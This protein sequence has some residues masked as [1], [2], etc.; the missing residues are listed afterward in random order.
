MHTERA[1]RFVRKSVL[2]AGTAPLRSPSELARAARSV[3]RLSQFYYVFIAYLIGVSTLQFRWASDGLPPTA[4]LWP[5]KLAQQLFS[6]VWLGW[7]PAITVIGLLCAIGAAVR[8]A[9]WPLR[10]GTFLYLFV[11]IALGNSYGSINHGQ[12]T[13]LFVSATLLFLPRV[14][15]GASFTFRDVSACL[16]ALSLTHVA[17]LLPYTLSGFWKLWHGGTEAF[18]PGALQR[19]LLDRLLASTGDV[20]FLLPVIAEHS[21]LSWV[22]WLATL[23]LEFFALLVVFR[24]HLHRPYAVALILFHVATHWTMGIAFENNVLLMGIFLVL[25]PLAPAKFSLAGALSSLPIVGIPVRI[26]TRRRSQA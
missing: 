7:H 14:R 21:G 22:M 2:N 1:L 4:P 19:I 25:S 26:W 10:F 18:A 20:P 6:G 11:H 9:A 3:M 8:P 17:V 12:H 24:P 23:Y 16:T 13:L 15:R 5:I